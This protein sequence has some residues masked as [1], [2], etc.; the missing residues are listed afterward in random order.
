M[1]TIICLT[2]GYSILPALRIVTR[3]H[4]SH[5]FWTLFAIMT[6]LAPLAFH[7]T[8][9]SFKIS[10]SRLSRFAYNFWLSHST[11]IF[12]ATLHQA[13]PLQYR[14]RFKLATIQ[15]IT[16]SSI[17]FQGSTVMRTFTSSSKVSRDYWTIHWCRATYQIRRRG[18]TAI[19]NFL[20]SSGKFAI[21]TK[22]S[23]ILCSRAQTSWIF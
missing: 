22:S 7:T 11:M 2:S 5:R 1:L 8:I 20:C 13:R 15:S 10:K 14:H 4:Y 23:C 9:W 16:C 3:Y 17:T 19:R 12:R 18:C 21:T 6:R